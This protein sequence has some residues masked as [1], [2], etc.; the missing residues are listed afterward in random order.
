M[1]PLIALDSTC[2]GNSPFAGRTP[3][4]VYKERRISEDTSSKN[5]LSKGG[6][7]LFMHSIEDI[8]KILFGEPFET[9]KR[10][11]E[12]DARLERLLIEVEMTYHDSKCLISTV[13]KKSGIS[14]GR[15]GHILHSYAAMTFK[16]LLTRYRLYQA[17]QILRSRDQRIIDT[18]L[19][20]GMNLSSFERSFRR[21]FHITPI[22]FRHDCRSHNRRI[23]IREQQV[24]PI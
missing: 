8:E 6:R 10:R 16:D 17:T 2:E 19:E 12:Y 1:K 20:V 13:S 5:C 22:Q 4:S 7:E 3:D 11:L 18:A 14:S 15:L 9:F 23:N 24:P 21:I